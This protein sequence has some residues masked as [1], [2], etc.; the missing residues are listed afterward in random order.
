MPGY[1]KKKVKRKK[2]NRL[3]MVSIALVL[4]AL[5]GVL[6]YQTME[7]EEKRG[8]CA[9][10]LNSIERELAE[11]ES[12]AAELERQRVYVQTKQ[13]IEEQAKE[14]LGLVNPNE[15]LMKPQE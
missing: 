1:G 12:R 4:A 3:A 8:A 7:L 2:Q 6:G 11:Q 9:D 10:R 5:V 13:Y 15:I 14:K